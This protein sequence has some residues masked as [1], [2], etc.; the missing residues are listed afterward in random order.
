LIVALDTYLKRRTHLPAKGSKEIVD[1]SR[2]LNRLGEKLFRPEERAETFRNE[3]GVYMKL[4]NFRRLDP[5]YTTNGRTGLPA[6]AKAEED[7]WAQF[8]GEPQKCRQVAEAII[9]SLDD[10][11][12]D[13]AWLEADTSQDLQEAP[14]GRLLTRKHLVRERNRKLVE[15]KRKQALKR[16]GRLACEVCKFDFSVR[17]GQRG[18]GFIECHHTRPVA[19]LA[20]GQKTHV[21]ELALVC[22]NCHRMIHR[23]KPWLS[24]AELREHLDSPS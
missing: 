7:V 1:L 10:P 22:A 20:S 21:D 18:K 2:T 16:H 4:M 24:V 8:A 13:A 17:Y 9:A 19:G 15:A 12:V 11:E 14:E 3:N 6:G 5:D 23:R